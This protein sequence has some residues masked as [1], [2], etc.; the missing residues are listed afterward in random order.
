MPRQK[1]KFRRGG[2]AAARM[3][4]RRLSKRRYRARRSAARR[5]G[6]QRYRAVKVIP[7]EIL[8]KSKYTTQVKIDPGAGARVIHQYRANDGY[9]PQYAVGGEQS[10]GWDQWSPMY[11]KQVCLGFKFSVKFI[12]LNQSVMRV[13]WILR[14]NDP[15]VPTT[16]DCLEG[17]WRGGYGIGYVGSRD[18][19][20]TTTLRGRRSTK[21][22][23]ELKS[24]KDQTDLVTNW[25]SPPAR[26]AYLSVFAEA[27]GVEDP[28][29]VEMIV[30]IEQLHLGF[31]QKLIPAS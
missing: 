10:S 22:Y 6:Y 8:F 31:E 25:A 20:F 15:V 26:V 12:N 29:S 2:S 5:G 14:D 7:K 16:K 18:G 1:R 19:K 28:P 4:R 21:K 30:T 27:V 13:G 9:D 17:R 11:A 23:F 24:L 3:K